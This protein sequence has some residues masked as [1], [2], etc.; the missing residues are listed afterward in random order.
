MDKRIKYLTVV[1]FLCLLTLTSSCS[2]VAMTGRNQLNLVPDMIMNS[3]G[4][5]SYSQFMSENKVSGNQQGSA[6]VTRVGY[7]IQKAA[8]KYCRVNGMSDRT[9]GYNWEFSLIENSQVNAWAM[10]G[11]KVV[12]YTGILPIT[13]SEEGLAVVIA[14]EIAHVI[15]RHGSERMTHGLLIEL[16]TVALS[17]ALSEHPQR[18]RDLFMKSFSI[19]ATYGVVLPYSRVQ[20]NEADHMG[21]VFMAMAGYNPNEALGFWQRMSATKKGTSAPEFLST[22]PADATRIRNIRALIPQA[23]QYYN[24]SG[25]GY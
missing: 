22:H 23:M 9:Q 16:G 20:E 8:E 15:A 3:L 25:S 12:V 6:T 7:R 17:K 14:H 11:G 13:R 10:P 5:Q 24:K 4:Q 18:T 1:I 21:L 19:G 2:Q